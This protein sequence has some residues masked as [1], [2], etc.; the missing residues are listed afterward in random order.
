M[1]D[2]QSTMES[3]N[4]MDLP[5]DILINI[6]MRL[7]AMSECSIRCVSKTVLDMI[8]GPA[9]RRLLGDAK[10]EAEAPPELVLFAQDYIEQGRKALPAMET[11]EYDD[12][13]NHLT[14]R[15][16]HE[17]RTCYKIVCVSRHKHSV[18]DPF[19]NLEGSFVTRV[20]VLGT[21]TW[22]EVPSVPPYNCDLDDAVQNV[23][24]YG[25]M[26]WLLSHLITAGRQVT[27]PILSFNFKKEEFCITQHP[28]SQERRSSLD[29]H[30]LT[31]RGAIAIADTCS[32]NGPRFET[33]Y[34]TCGEWE[35]GIFFNS[36]SRLVKKALFFVDLRSPVSIKPVA[37]PTLIWIWENTGIF[38]LG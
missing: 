36:N 17:G 35:H 16:K 25:D 27:R 13:N 7:L 23:C 24:A 9:Y 21:R 14:T 22:R 10:I 18:D 31:L 1:A 34:Y 20:L 29:L 19:I 12:G 11:L 3:T 33:W 5:V 6:F 26:H 37:Y 2:I 38:S 30:L 15:G 8:D 4:L 32:S 28:I